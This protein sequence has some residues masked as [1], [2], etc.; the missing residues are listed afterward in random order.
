MQS[1]QPQNPKPP[2]AP[3]WKAGLTE[4]QHCPRCGART[5]SRPGG[6]CRQPAMPNGRCRMHGGCSTGPRTP[7]GMARLRAAR[8]I[9]GGR[10]AEARELRAMIRELKVGAKR[11]CEVV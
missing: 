10:S 8:T 7:E 1:D 6:T 4:A 2:S 11:L 3:F 5:R 9:H